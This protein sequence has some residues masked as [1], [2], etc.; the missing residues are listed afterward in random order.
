MANFQRNDA[1]KDPGFLCH[2]W[3]DQTYLD[4]LVRPQ[5]QMLETTVLLHLKYEETAAIL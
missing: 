5:T 2:V 4:L 3:H 1:L